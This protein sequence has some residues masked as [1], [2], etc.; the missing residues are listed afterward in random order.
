MQLFNINSSIFQNTLIGEYDQYKKNLSKNSNFSEEVKDYMNGDMLFSINQNS[1]SLTNLMKDVWNTTTLEDEN[2]KGTFTDGTDWLNYI[3]E[4]IIKVE[5][6][7]TLKE[8]IQLIHDLVG[9][10]GDMF[11]GALLVQGKTILNP[12]HPL[13]ALI[14]IDNYDE[15]NY[16]TYKIIV[17]KYYDRDSMKSHY[18]SDDVSH[19]AIATNIRNLI[20]L[21]SNKQR[22]NRTIKSLTVASKNDTPLANIEQMYRESMPMDSEYVGDFIIIPHTLITKGIAAP[23]YGTSVVVRS[24]NA[25][26]G[27]FLTPF[28]SANISPS[29][30]DDNNPEFNSVCTG[31]KSQVTME[32]LRTLNHANLSSPL[33]PNCI[34][35]GA[36]EYADECIKQSLNIYKLGGFLNDTENEETTT[37]ERGDN[38]SSLEEQILAEQDEEAELERSLLEATEEKRPTYEDFVD[39]ARYTA[40]TYQAQPTDTFGTVQNTTFVT[41]DQT[42]GTTV[43]DE[44]FPQTPTTTFTE[45]G[46]FFPAFEKFTGEVEPTADTEDT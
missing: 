12:L 8:A 34:G 6:P 37:I 39:A 18:R 14:M 33:S 10:M 5:E 27:A 9:L 15:L 32:G 1:Q 26:K 29:F 11:A 43:Q 7:H 45:R 3:T 13:S 2:V 22:I 23:Y 17:Y 46:R 28:Q 21:Y 19:E 36:L 4:S 35:I 16:N 40:R 24:D 31:N 30:G 38:E 20:S 42:T 41:T 44:R 25:S